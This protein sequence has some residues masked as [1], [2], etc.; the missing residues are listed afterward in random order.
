MGFILFFCEGFLLQ[1]KR[2]G[3]EFFKNLCLMES[4]LNHFFYYIA[5]PVV[6]I[7]I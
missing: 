6:A 1:K 7:Q 5:S 3:D 4:F 2:I